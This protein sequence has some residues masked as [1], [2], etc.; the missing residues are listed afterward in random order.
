MD[1][2][3]ESHNAE[4]VNAIA[5]AEEAKQKAFHTQL[6]GALREVL[7]DDDSDSLPMRLKR[8][9]FICTDIKD[10]KSDLRWMKWVAIAGVSLFGAVGLPVC[11]WVILQVI[12]LSTQIAVLL[13]TK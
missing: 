13:H 4:A 10:I 8:I 5:V 12:H 6:V 1:P 3:Q 11:G 2:L 9:P 7:V